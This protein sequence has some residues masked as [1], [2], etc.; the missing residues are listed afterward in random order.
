VKAP[1]VF[2]TARGRGPA[3]VLINGWSAS[4]KTWPAA[5]LRELAQTHRVICPDNRGSGWSRFA[6]V[7]FTL[8]DLADDVA[9]VLDAEEVETATVLGISMGGMI[10]QEVG[11]RHPERVERLVLIGTRAPAP[12]FVERPGW[13]VAAQMLRPP[14]RRPLYEFF[15]AQWGLCAAP[16][17]ADRHPERLDELARQMADRPTPRL[18]LAYQLRA[19]AGWGGAKRLADIEAPTVVVHGAEDR[20]APPANGRRLAELIPDAE[21]VELPGVGHLVPYE[22]PDVLVPVFASTRGRR[23]S[24]APAEAA[25]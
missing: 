10:A 23:G 12:E 24:P 3:L 17:F 2:W 18:L 21:Y 15:R 5:W 8:A 14:G 16:G 6:E 7:P 20:L 19:M 13:G 11:L 25:R 9:D 22:A 1:Q 4:C